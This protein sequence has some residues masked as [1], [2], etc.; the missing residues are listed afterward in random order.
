MLPQPKSINQETNSFVCLNCFPIPCE[1]QCGTVISTP[2]RKVPR[3]ITTIVL[4]TTNSFETM[5]IRGTLQ[6]GSARNV[7]MQLPREVI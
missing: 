6:S 1:F 5:S 3:L 7:N 4:V 2:Q